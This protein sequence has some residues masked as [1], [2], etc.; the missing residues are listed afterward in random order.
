MEEKTNGILKNFEEM[1]VEGDEK[2]IKRKRDKEELE[3]N[4]M[5]KYEEQGNKRTEK[6]NLNE[7]NQIKVR[8][9]CRKK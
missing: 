4:E 9:P 6:E 8:K 5:K 3:E 2:K 1:K 7:N